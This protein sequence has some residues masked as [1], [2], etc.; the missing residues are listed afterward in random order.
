LSVGLDNIDRQLKRVERRLELV[1]TPA[2]A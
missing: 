1:E 2:G